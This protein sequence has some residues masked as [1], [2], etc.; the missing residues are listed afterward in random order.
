MKT[1]AKYKSPRLCRLSCILVLIEACCTTILL[2]SRY[3]NSYS[4]NRSEKSNKVY[5]T[6]AE[7]GKKLINYSN[8]SNLQINIQN[9]Y[10]NQ[11]PWSARENHNIFRLTLTLQFQKTSF[12]PNPLT[13]RKV[14]DFCY[15]AK[16]WWLATGTSILQ[17]FER[18][19]SI[20]L[21]FQKNF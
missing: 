1:R 11:L 2:Y 6:S 7:V 15:L 9:I 17:S 8:A 5:V 21:V 18:C 20:S 12:T 10:S 14:P 16:R 19:E 3:G 4:S 13:K